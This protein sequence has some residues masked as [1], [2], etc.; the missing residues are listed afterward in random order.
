LR[1]N[2][3]IVLKYLV[4]LSQLKITQFQ[5]WMW[6]VMLICISLH[7]PKTYGGG[8]RVPNTLMLESSTCE[9]AHGIAPMSIF[10]FSF[11]TLRLQ[12]ASSHQNNVLQPCKICG[13]GTCLYFQGCI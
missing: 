9:Y 6:L 11:L 7:H 12:V 3:S 2:V 10:I 1:E 8:F 13:Y 5:G 4:M